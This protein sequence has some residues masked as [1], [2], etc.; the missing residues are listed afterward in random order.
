MRHTPVLALLFLVHAATASAA[1]VTTPAAIYGQLFERV[2]LEHV[3]PDSKNL[4]DALPVGAPQQVLAEYQKVK[5][6]PDFDLRK[7]A[8]A[9]FTPPPQAG[10]EYH[11]VPGQD[12]R[13]H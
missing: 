12:V 2:Q 5:D 7:F 3:Y 10:A 6:R 9:H 4:V 1:D 8:A 13:E 11:T